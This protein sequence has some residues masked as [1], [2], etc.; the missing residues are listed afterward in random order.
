MSRS[1]TRF[2]AKGSDK[3][4]ARRIGGTPLRF[5]RFKGHLKVVG[6]LLERGADKEKTGSID[7]HRIHR[8]LLEIMKLLLQCGTTPILEESLDLVKEHFEASNALL[9]KWHAL[10]PDRRNAAPRLGWDYIDVPTKW[11][12]QNHSQ[13]PA[14]FQQQVA[15]VALASFNRR[16]GDLVQQVAEATHAQMVIHPKKVSTH[17]SLT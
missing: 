9:R 10:T 2:V 11:T 6:L 16:P 7:E 15:A 5:A 13:F 3:E 14:D 4:K 1:E 8:R 12:P 17:E